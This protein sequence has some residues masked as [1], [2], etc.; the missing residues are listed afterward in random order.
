M[1]SVQD[2]AASK[3]FGL[4]VAQLAGVPK[5]V[6]KAAQQKLAILENA[7]LVSEAGSSTNED[8][9]R[10]SKTEDASAKPKTSKKATTSEPAQ[11]QLLFPD[12]P[13]PVVEAL[14]NLSPDELSPRQAL[15]L[16]YTLKRLS[17][18]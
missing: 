12:K 6:I 9:D 16:I 17:Q 1:H 3:S 7:H 2:G 13:H 4:Q 10:S 18:S 15:D 8:N 11:S 14:E 5:P